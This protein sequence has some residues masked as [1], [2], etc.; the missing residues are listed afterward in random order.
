M[1]VSPV[2][3][4][5]DKARFL[6]E[7]RALRDRAAVDFEE[8]AARTH[9]PSAVLKDAENGPGLP[10]LPVLAAYVRACGGD[11]AEWEERWRLLALAADDEAG[12]PTRP[13]GASAAAVAGARAGVTMGPAEAAD[14]ERIK[15]ALRAHRQ[16]EEEESRTRPADARVSGQRTMI[17]NGA[18]H[19]EPRAE[20]FDKSIAS[21]TATAAGSPVQGPAVA[22]DERFKSSSGASGSAS[23]G[24]S[25]EK[26]GSAASTDSPRAAAAQSRNL[27]SRPGL[28]AAIVAI[29]V[30]VCIAALALTLFG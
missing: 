1:E 18:R 19:K 28:L 14:T 24:S 26:S 8:L 11:V 13:A 16:R 30:L 6:A 20:T 15:A 2:G 7:F 9:F 17:T 22:A 21:A 3:Q 12:L 27:T 4:S 25:R 5:D 10:G 29:V 23:A